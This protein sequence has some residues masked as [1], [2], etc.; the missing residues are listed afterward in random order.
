MRT[1]SQTH[2]KN[3]E[4]LT[5][6]KYRPDIDGLR[7]IAV[8]LVVG[9]HMFPSLI[10]GGF[11]GVDIFFVISG[12]LIST[13]IFDN[14]DKRSFSYLEFY[15]RRIKRIFPALILILISTYILGWYLLLPD[16]Y[17]KLGL[18]TFAGT[19][20]F[21]NLAL[22][23]EA[24]YFDAAS[25]TKPLL[26]LWSLGV[27]EQFYIFW[28]LLLTLVWKFRLNFLRSTLFFAT[29]SFLFNIITVDS[30][31]TAAFYS[32]ISRFWELMIG[33]VLAYLFLHK[34][35]FILIHSNFKSIIGL[36]AILTASFALNK[37]MHYPSWLALLPTLGAFLIISSS[38]SIFNRHI[39][40]NRILVSIGLISYPLYL[41]H[42]PVL[43][44]LRIMNNGTPS[45]GI[46]I[47]AIISSFFLA[48]LTYYFIEKPMRIKK[49]GC[50]KVIILSLLMA[51]IGC[52]GFITYK[53]N[54]LEF[55]ISKLMPEII[56]TKPNIDKEW[57]INQCFLKD[58]QRQ[59]SDSCIE[60][61]AKPLVFL[62][63]DS[64]AADI[65]PGLNQLKEKYQLRM[66]QYTAS[67]CKPFIN[68]E[69]EK[70]INSKKPNCLQLNHDVIG[71]IKKETPDYVFLSSNW[72]A[73]ADLEELKIT[74]DLLKSIGVKKIVLIGP[75]PKWNESL[76]MI[77]F[78]YHRN[79]H[80]KPP[81]YMKNNNLNQIKAI[82]DA[83]RDF[84]KLQE[85]RY[86]SSIDI[87]CSNDGCLT[88]T[89][90]S[91]VDITFFDT[92][93][94]TPQGATYKADCILKKLFELKTT[95]V[96]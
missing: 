43:V 42:W 54:G 55:R 73:I 26:H 82:D 20:F 27:E 13:I 2:T 65:Y 93:H 3:S 9:F 61:N 96:N 4:Q 34:S 18:H 11:I 60:R 49:N 76:P 16:E 75:D 92:D 45:I 64:H 24:G 14:F 67:G 46:R 53:R 66:A 85:V 81:L 78:S 69:H 51:L 36:V 90:E 59:F 86:F 79:E 10:K 47:V 12:F 7:A 28:P 35:H 30:H 72:T 83:M 88:R 68:D 70:V 95:L 71:I 22:W 25:D 52:I 41:W 80:K 17:K 37:D 63:G 15:S 39:L 23:N 1:H 87:L 62:W 38:S 77:V 57:R 91:S 6:H 44:F 5:H 48:Y 21:S 32:P 74:I 8:L 84:A 56:G 94:L 31:P 89:S 19:G 50:Y 29:V 58:N 33:G 40:G